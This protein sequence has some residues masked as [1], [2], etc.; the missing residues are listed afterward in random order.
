M[1]VPLKFFL[2]KDYFLVA[3]SAP[4]V[5]STVV[6]SVV[7]G[8]SIAEESTAVESELVVSVLLL[9]QAAKANTTQAAKA[10]VIFFILISFF[11]IECAANL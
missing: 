8:C 5:E 11:S 4:V 9:P 7:I 1:Q 3:E 10:K 2:V 6:E